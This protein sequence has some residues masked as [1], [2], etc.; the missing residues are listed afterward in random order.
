MNSKHLFNPALIAV[1]FFV[2]LNVKYVIS[3]Y[4]SCL[5]VNQLLVVRV[6]KYVNAE[7]R[8]ILMEHHLITLM[9]F[10]EDETLKGCFKPVN[11]SD[12]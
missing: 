8:C 2:L 7:S 3:L 6:I 11:Y 4:E 12:T 5:P 10:A 1:R 9:V